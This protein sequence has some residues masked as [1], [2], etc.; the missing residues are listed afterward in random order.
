[1]LLDKLAVSILGIMLAKSSKIPGQ[2]VIR[3]GEVVIRASQFTIRAG[4]DF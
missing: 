3:V 4:Q 1:M 2:G